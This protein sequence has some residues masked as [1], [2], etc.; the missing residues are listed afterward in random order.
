M[1]VFVKVKPRTTKD[2]R[3]RRLLFD[4]EAFDELKISLSIDVICLPGRMF[5]VKSSH[6][7]GI[8]LNGKP[9]QAPG[10]VVVQ[11][12]LLIIAQGPGK[13]RHVAER[14]GRKI[15]IQLPFI[16]TYPVAGKQ[17]S[18][19]LPVGGEGKTCLTGG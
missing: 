9:H 15:L 5:F 3:I 14:E 13:R 17:L 8:F 1:P 6:R 16:G 10:R 19:W 2:T 11:D 12:E 7:E 18:G 4:E